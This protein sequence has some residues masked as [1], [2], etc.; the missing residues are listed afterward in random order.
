MGTNIIYIMYVGAN[1][2][3]HHEVRTAA[4]ILLPRFSNKIT[5]LTW[6]WWVK[7][8]QTQGMKKFLRSYK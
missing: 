2:N 8:F 3:Y 5:E 7:Q 6:G 1:I 4:L